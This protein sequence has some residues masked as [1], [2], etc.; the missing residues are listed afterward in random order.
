MKLKKLRK[1]TFDPILHE[2]W[3]GDKQ[4]IGLTSLLKK[5]GLSPSEYAVTDPHVLENAAER[6]TQFHQRLEDYDNYG[7]VTLPVILTNLD[8]ERFDYTGAF[9]EYRNLGLNVIASEY[10][11]TDGKV[12]ATFIDKVVQVGEN[13]VDIDDVKTTSKVHTESVSWQCS[14]GAYLFE[15]QNPG[16]KV[17]KIHCIHGRDN[18]TKYIELPRV[19]D[20]E[21]EKLLKSEREGAIY[22]DMRETPN[23]GLILDANELTEYLSLSEQISALKASLDAIQAKQKELSGKVLDYML[24]NN[25]SE[26]DSEGGKFTV[27]KG[28]TR[29]SV[30]SAKLKEQCPDVYE[31]FSKTSEVAPSLIFKAK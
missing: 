15:K 25:L 26:L 6:G 4:L 12:V 8:G 27:R 14:V 24:E 30:D 31:K 2:Y 7:T 5:H 18:H 1:V 9:N 19:P 22:L 11:V 13:E 23:A 29:T 21:I 20:E 17:R 28:G 10:L 3:M 16:I